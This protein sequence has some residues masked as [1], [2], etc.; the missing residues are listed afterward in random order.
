MISR[1]KYFPRPFCAKC[2]RD[3]AMLRKYDAT[4]GQRYIEALCHGETERI[5]FADGPDEKVTVFA[6]AQPKAEAVNVRPTQRP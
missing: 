1:M 4:T 5:D 3:A 2:N 6:P